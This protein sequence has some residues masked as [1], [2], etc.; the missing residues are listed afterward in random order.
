VID[1]SSEVW[2]CWRFLDRPTL[3]DPGIFKPSQF[4]VWHVIH[5]SV[6]I[7]QM[8]AYGERWS[9]ILSPNEFLFLEA[10]AMCAEKKFLSLLQQSTIELPHWYPSSSK[11]IILCLLLGLLER[12]IRLDL[13]LKVHLQGQMFSSWLHDISKLTKLSPDYFQGLTAELLGMPGFCAAYTVVTDIFQSLTSQQ[14]KIML[15]NYPDITYEPLLK[16]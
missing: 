11:S 5:D 15:Q 1:W 9:N 7:W 3:I 2:R 6:H 13:D 16:I 14:R 10:Q 4:F 8:Q 12:E